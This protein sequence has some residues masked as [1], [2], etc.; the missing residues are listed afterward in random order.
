MDFSFDAFVD[1]SFDYD[2]ET[3]KHS[4]LWLRAE[5]TDVG[6]G[7]ITVADIDKREIAK[8]VHLNILNNNVSLIM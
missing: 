5:Q 7:K 8:G 1:G 4:C 2:P 3:K 6:G